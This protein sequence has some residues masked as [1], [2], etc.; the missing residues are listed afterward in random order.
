MVILK[1]GRDFTVRARIEALG[2][3]TGWRRGI[4]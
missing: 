4:C 1:V 2:E 3:E